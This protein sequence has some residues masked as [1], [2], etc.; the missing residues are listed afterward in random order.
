MQLRRAKGA[1]QAGC[2]QNDAADSRGVGVEV[3]G[4]VGV[5]V[6]GAP[7]PEID[8][9]TAAKPSKPVA[10]IHYSCISNAI[11]GIRQ[12]STSSEK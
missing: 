9:R 8:V 1:R 10:V 3:C 4:V 11:R 5:T 2:T 12:L 7:R 6:I